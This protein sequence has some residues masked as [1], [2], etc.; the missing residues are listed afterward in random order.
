M[1]HGTEAAGADGSIE[2]SLIIVPVLETER[3]SLRRLR[4]E[5]AAFILRLLNQ[6]SFIRNVGDRGVRT[7]EDAA[8]Y[9]ERGPMASYERHGFGLYLV[10]LKDGGTPIG[11]CGVLKRDELPDADVGYS[12]V[13]EFWSQGFA[14][15][16]AR[17][18]KDYARDT[19][20]LRRLVA[21]VAPGND[22]SARLLEKLGFAFERMIRL[23]PDAE[24]LRL[25]SSAL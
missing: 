22:A 3:L 17:A 11:T 8:G 9:I 16:A 1:Q 5:D 6:P 23:G 10:E 4:R 21:I 13:P 15:E 25:F 19:L 20:G 12:L 14:L 18:V 7:L 24:E 2:S